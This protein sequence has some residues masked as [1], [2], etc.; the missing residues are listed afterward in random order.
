MNLR[1]LIALL[2]TL[3]AVGSATAAEPKGHRILGIAINDGPG[4]D[5]DSSFELAR[6]A[7]LQAI[8]LSLNWDEIELEP[9]VY[10]PNPDW[11]KTAS[12]VYPQFGT[13]V[14][15]A[16]NPIDTTMDRRPSWLKAKSWDDHAVITAYVRLLT[17]ALDNAKSLDLLSL[18]LGNEVDGVLSRS[19]ADWTA[20][21]SFATTTAKAIRTIRPKLLIGVKTTF[22]AFKGPLS[23]RARTLHQ[24]MDVALLTYY[25]LNDDFTVKPPASVSGDL[26]YAVKTL[27]GKPLHFAE[28][29]YPSSVECGS[30]PEQQADFVH[31]VF[32][33]WDKH[34]NQI[35][36]MN[37]VWLND[38]SKAEWGGYVQY[39][40]VNTPCF[41]QYLATLGLRHNNRDKPAFQALTVEAHKR[42]W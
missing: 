29:G 5:Y 21:T 27:Q 3:A 19:A 42:G 32:E 25:P 2:L 23:D 8:E 38:I 39:Y 34:A 11:L 18:S 4:T 37:F 24:N 9:G 10:R 31:Q 17:W 36:F 12:S 20:Y 14:A 41:I 16:I 35:G 28:I 33:T 26:A 13:K 15:L 1:I 40:G 6:A 22:A 30:S 7:G